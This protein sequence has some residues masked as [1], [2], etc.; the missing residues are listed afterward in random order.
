[1]MLFGRRQFIKTT[2]SNS[3]MPLISRRCLRTTKYN[4]LIIY[5][6][7]D[8]PPPKLS[9][10]PEGVTNM[11]EGGRGTGKGEFDSPDWNCC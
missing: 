8:T 3:S 4:G 7:P 10:L 11:F 9:A 5:K 6:V 1:M 2:E